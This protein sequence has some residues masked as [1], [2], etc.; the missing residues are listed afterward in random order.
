MKRILT[1]LTLALAVWGSVYALTPVLAKPV[2]SVDRMYQYVMSKNPGSSFSYEIAQAYYDTGNRWGIRGDIALCQACIETGW[3]RYEGGTAVTPSDHNYCG[4]GVTTLGQ[5][6]CQFGSVQTGVDAHLQHLWSYATTAPLPSGWTKVDPRF[7]YNS[8]HSAYF[9]NFGNGV[10]AMAS[11]YGTRIMQLYNEMAA[12]TVEPPSI[13]ANPASLSFNVVKGSKNPSQTISVTGKWLSS[14]IRVASNSGKYTLSTK[15]LN[16]KG[17]T[18]TVTL[19]TSFGEGSWDD[20]VAL[21]SGF[22]TAKVRITVPV[23]TVISAGV[24]TPKPELT[25]SASSATLSATEGEAAPSTALT[26]TGKDL[27]GEIS[28]TSS[29]S[30]VKVAPASGWSAT[31][32]GT[33]TISAD[34]SAQGSYSATVTVKAGALSQQFNVTVNISAK[35]VVRGTIAVNGTTQWMTA[36]LGS[37]C[38]QGFQ[39]TGKVVRTVAVTGTNIN[40]QIS[41]SCADSQIS[42]E[43]ASLPAAGGNVAI[44]YSP[45]KVTSGYVTI[46]VT[47][48]ASNADAVTIN[49]KTKWTGEM[50]SIEPEPAPKNPAITVSTAS[51]SLSAGKGEAAPSANVT[52]S[53]VDLE[54]DIT[55]T[56]SNSKVTVAKASGWN[57]T[58]GGTLVITADAATAG[59]YNATVTV[60][61]GSVSKQIAVAVAIAK[62]PVITVSTA[63]V[64]L[65]AVKGE[66]APSANLTV[67]AVD[68]EQDITV[69][70]SNSKVTVAKASGWNAT[71]GGTLVI[72]ADAATAGSYNATVTV[73]S[74]SVSKQIAVAVTIAKKPVIT[75]STASVSLSAGKGEAAPS[76]NVTV[77]AE[78]LDSDITVTSSNSKVTV[79]K[80]SGWNATT[81]GTL[82][83]TA[84]TATSGSYSATVTVASGSVSKQIAV[85]VAIAKKPVINLSTANVSLSATEGEAAS[86]ANVTVSAEDLDSD[87]AVTSSNSNVTVSKNG[88]NATTGGTL[89]IAASTATPGSYSATVTVA[90]GSVS[91]Q[92]AVAV[93]IEKKPE[94]VTRGSLAV[95][96]TTLWMTAD[97]DA[98]FKANG[99]VVRELTVT[100]TGISGTIKASSSNSQITV[101]PATL[102]AQGGTFTIVYTPTKASTSYV[103]IPVTISADN[104]DAV[105][106]NCKTKWSGKYPAGSLAVSA[107]TFWMT[108]DA[109]AGFKSNGYVTRQFN[110]TGSGIIGEISVRSS[111]SQITVSPATLPAEGGTVTMTFTPTKSG[112]SYVTIPVYVSALNASQVTVNCKTKWSGRRYTKGVSGINDVET[113]VLADSTEYYTLQG[114]RVE[115]ENLTPGLYIRRQGNT[116]TKVVIR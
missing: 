12:F 49:L 38:D 108:A 47:V 54:Q 102:P 67:S 107:T 115:A 87:I 111:D 29:D 70:S 36:G 85:A 63:S 8:K 46:P 74:G 2:A 33:L 21:E 13:K 68:L 94:V 3:F 86:S 57:A 96:G 31:A 27:A 26:V 6:G 59:S 95:S 52:V 11:G 23:K 22:G 113:D 56:S 41:L 14:E 28:Y 83:I 44:V 9:E 81:G 61:S 7:G 72:T 98:G 104:A 106:V 82:V 19:N 78:D 32:G 76:A 90:S 64:S 30:R 69:T 66:D 109:D 89:V 43:P 10:W 73:A 105:T 114:V 103:T 88:W 101:S 112:T 91:K 62:K 110:V 93:K 65:S 20:Y 75:V 39:T 48:S 51:V 55:V 80:A 53:A 35:P 92:I 84:S 97:A 45:T 99:R 16:A 79:A 17:G 116:V 25:L 77:S 34:A 1:F 50:P 15:T 58:T 5:K 42:F 40:G 37:N 4:L 18:V 100:G 24:Q 71:T 60:A